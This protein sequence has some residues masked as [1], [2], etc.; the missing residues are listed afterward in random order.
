MPF[1]LGRFFNKSNRSLWS[2]K[3]LT[4][5]C[6]VSETTRK[7]NDGNS[8]PIIITCINA[9]VWQTDV[10]FNPQSRILKKNQQKF[11]ATKWLC[12]CLYNHLVV[13]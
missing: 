10:S 4:S 3:W 6:Y 13:L 11:F 1:S 7:E 9:R 8:Y 2:A 5:D 12:L